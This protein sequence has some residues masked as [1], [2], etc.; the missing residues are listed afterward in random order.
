[1]KTSKSLIEYAFAQPESNKHC[2]K[3]GNQNHIAQRR[4]IK[5]NRVVQRRQNHKNK[6][7]KIGNMCKSLIQLKKDEKQFGGVILDQ[8]LS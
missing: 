5:T 1:L 4:E 3:T 2:T 8:N 6:G 7:N